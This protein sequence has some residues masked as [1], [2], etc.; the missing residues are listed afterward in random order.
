MTQRVAL[1]SGAGRGIGRGIAL[2]V[3]KSGYA[4]AVGDL[5]E[6]N[7]LETVAMIEQ[8]G[9]KAAFVFLDVSS[10]ETVAAAV[11]KTEAS[12]GV[13]DCVINCAGWDA[14][15]PFVKT[16]EAF[17]NKVVDINYIG[18]LRMCH[19]VLPG[20][21]ERGFGRIINI[22]SDAARVGSSM[23]AVYS[24]A[25]GA[26]ISFGK[27]LARETARKGVTVNSVCPGPT[28]TPGME[29]TMDVGNLKLM[30]AMVRAV[31]M[32]RMGEPE[33]IGAAVAFLASDNAGFITGQTLSV[34]GGLTMA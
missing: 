17:W 20:M 22:A 25:K 33:D 5:N 15:M 7:S 30:E 9:G 10:T 27:T 14:L 1:I 8:A 18:T 13:I 32:G 31:P 11:A 23:E 26:I 28:R 29:E 24:G 3:A 6:A 4:V 21:I 34:S 16:D 2:E 12:L 19:A